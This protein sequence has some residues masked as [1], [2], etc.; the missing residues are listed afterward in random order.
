MVILP[1]MGT[2]CKCVKCKEYTNKIL[3]DK[4]NEV[5]KQLLCK[6]TRDV[7]FLRVVERTIQLLKYQEE[8]LKSS[9]CLNQILI[10]N[11]LNLVV[12]DLEI[13]KICL[14]EQFKKTN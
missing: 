11:Q 3:E 1:N 13:V 2:T 12:K 14:K 9:D 5:N 10:A 6:Q 7:Q 8:V 4:L